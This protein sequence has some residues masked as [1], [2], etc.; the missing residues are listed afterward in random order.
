MICRLEVFRTLS[1]KTDTTTIAKWLIKRERNDLRR[2]RT[3]RTRNDSVVKRP[4]GHQTS[5]ET[6]VNRTKRLEQ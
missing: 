4:M 6:G 1:Y 2:K 3:G 5:S